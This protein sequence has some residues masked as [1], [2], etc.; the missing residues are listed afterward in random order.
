MPKSL[1]V[2][3]AYRLSGEREKSLT[4]YESARSLLEAEV[5][6]SPDDPR[7]HSSLGIACAALGRKEEAIREGKQAV[8]LLPVARDAFY[9]LPYVE[10]LAFIYAL[11]GE[12]EAALERLDYLLSIPSWISVA[13]LR[14]DPQ[15]DP[16]R[17]H[18]G[19]TNLLDKHSR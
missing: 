19:F 9:G 12:T 16:I 17:N 1:L 6:H 2:A 10:D 11:S 18:P 13:W 5:K 8:E 15:W 3:Y 7:Y 14:M 4:S